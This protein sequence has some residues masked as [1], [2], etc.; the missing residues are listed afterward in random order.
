[1]EVLKK[2]VLIVPGTSPGLVG[3]L[4]I[5]GSLV[6]YDTVGVDCLIHEILVPSFFFCIIWFFVREEA[7]HKSAALLLPYSCK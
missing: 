3:W 6:D 7:F 4:I 2:A 5:L 1:M